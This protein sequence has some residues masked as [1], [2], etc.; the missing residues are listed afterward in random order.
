[1]DFED[2][3]TPSLKFR[4]DITPLSNRPKPKRN[5]FSFSTLVE[6]QKLKFGLMSC[7]N[8][9]EGSIVQLR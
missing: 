1:M 8:A 7:E 2:N 9:S 4:T 3:V 6:R 5:L